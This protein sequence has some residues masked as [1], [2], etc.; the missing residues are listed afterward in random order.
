MSQPQ[1]PIIVCP[2]RIKIPYRWSAGR[3]GTHFLQA[4]RDR[5]QIVGLRC[6]KCRRV[7]VPPQPHCPA[8]AVPGTEWVD[9]GPQGTLTTWTVVRESVP[10]VDPMPVPYAFGAV[11]LDGAD[12]DLVHWILDAPPS[13]LR[14]GM[15]FEAVFAES[16]R[17][18][19]RDLRGF[20]PASS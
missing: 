12:T 10:G 2:G 1:E 4:L 8:C 15:R 7:S 14:A 9:A 19:I 16:R 5:A 17:G 13:D 6:P 3:A 11:R 20:R 18:D